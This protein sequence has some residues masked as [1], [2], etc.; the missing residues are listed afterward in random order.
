[1]NRLRFALMIPILASAQ[2][3][4]PTV[5]PETVVAEAGGKTYK[6]AGVDKV[7]KLYPPQMQM[8]IRTDPKR[9]L[10]NILMMRYLAAEAEN[11]KLDRES[12]LKET[13]EFQRIYSMMQAELSQRRNF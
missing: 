13:L 3:Q 12:P 1:M 4:A 5:P 9:A 10:E 8:Q 7:M 11:A 6:A 2:P